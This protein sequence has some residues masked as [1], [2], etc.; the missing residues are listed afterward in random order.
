LV[1][2]L[3][4]GKSRRSF[5]FVSACVF[6]APG[7]VTARVLCAFGARGGRVLQMDSPDRVL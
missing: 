2:Y 6:V 4:F 1:V 7:L 3:E 5:R